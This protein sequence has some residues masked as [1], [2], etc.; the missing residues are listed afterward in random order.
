M[1]PWLTR[2]VLNVAH[3]GGDHE[4][5]SNTLRALTTAAA[6]GAHMLEIDVHA[7]ADGHVVV[8]HDPTVDRTTNGTGPIDALALAEIQRLDAAHWF[9][10]GRG[11]D[12]H[13]DAYPLRGAR[14]DPPAGARGEDFAIPT[15]DEVFEAVPDLL[16]SIDIKRGP[17]ETPSYEQDVADAIARHR[18]QDRV[19]VASFHDEVLH[20]FRAIAPGVT[21]SAATEEATAFV[22]GGPPGGYQLLQLP[23]EY[24]GTQVVTPELVERAHEQG[25]A[26]HAWTVNDP[27]EMRALIAM[28]VDGIVTDRPSVLATVLQE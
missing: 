2:R 19:V 4:A 8:C 23:V 1:N 28:G 5:P 12:R 15:L 24:Q 10:P 9:V 25:V 13:A 11:P 18:A 6:R 16:V 14:F 20:R 3:Q 22:F 7:T 21:T 17:P 27:A 26:V